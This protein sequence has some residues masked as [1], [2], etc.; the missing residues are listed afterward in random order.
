MYENDNCPEVSVFLFRYNLLFFLTNMHFPV[1]FLPSPFRAE[2]FGP[3]S[4]IEGTH[5]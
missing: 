1:A 3:L 2:L 4:L 5:R